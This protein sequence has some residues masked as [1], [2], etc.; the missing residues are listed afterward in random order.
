MGVPSSDLL[1]PSSICLP[2]ALLVH[3]T[4][5]VFSKGTQVRPVSAGIHR[6]EQWREGQG[7]TLPLQSAGLEVVKGSKCLGWQ[8]WIFPGRTWVLPGPMLLTAEAP[9]ISLSFSLSAWD[10]GSPWSSFRTPSEDSGELSAWLIVRSP[11]PQGLSPAP[12]FL[13]HP[14]F[15][16]IFRM[17][18]PAW[19]PLLS[20]AVQKLPTVLFLRF[21][22]P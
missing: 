18:H 19:H 16:Q 8:P 9:S 4:A 20:S 10:A 15:P 5:Q 13:S 12:P 17:S 1:R 21:E 11:P 22:L 7:K 2:L 6:R 3:V 14:A